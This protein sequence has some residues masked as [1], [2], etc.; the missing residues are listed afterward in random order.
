MYLKNLSYK[1]V[2]ILFLFVISLIF[3]SCGVP[4][5]KV[6]IQSFELQKVALEKEM[7]I[8]KITNILVDRGFDIKMTNKDAGIITSEYKKF[9]SIGENPPFDYYMQIRATVRPKTDKILVKL[10]PIIKGQ[11]RLNV[12]AFTEEELAY[13]TGNPKT[14]KFIKSMDP[15][16][17]YRGIALTKFNNVVTEVAETF[18]L[19]FDD[20][21]KNETKTPK[22]VSLTSDL[23]LF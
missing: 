12:A 1:F 13:Y 5:T 14:L 18:G 11:N 21:V 3:F 4:I 19:T 9:A 2:A 8:N 17:G 22:K 16:T 23:Q 6:H 7:A 15:E 20:V 10:S